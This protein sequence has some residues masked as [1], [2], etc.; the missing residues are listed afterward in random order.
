MDVAVKRL[1]L[2][3]FFPMILLL[4]IWLIFISEHS[5]GL[6]LAYHGIYP[7]RISGLQGI[8]FSPLIHGDWRHLFANSIPLLALGALLFYFY[9]TLAFR[10]LIVSYLFPGIA[11]WLIGRPAYHIGASGII[12][13]LAGFLFLSGLLRKH[14]GLMAVSLLVVIQYGAMVWGVLPLEEGVSWESHLAGL[15]AGL[16]MAWLYRFKGPKAYES[17]SAGLGQAVMNEDSDN[18]AAARLPWDEYE[19]EGPRK[20]FKDQANPDDIN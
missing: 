13:A 7:R 10:V 2:S 1:V 18:E 17:Y 12:Y 9:N 19:V 4:V 16:F 5:L 3:M 6:D 15:S 20:P 8:L 14:V 11:V